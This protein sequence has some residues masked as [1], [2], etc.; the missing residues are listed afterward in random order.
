MKQSETVVQQP[1]ATTTATADGVAPTVNPASGR[2]G[3]IRKPLRYQLHQTPCVP[4]GM[5]WIGEGED[6]SK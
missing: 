5:K 3:L 6:S 4:R 1:E 2:I